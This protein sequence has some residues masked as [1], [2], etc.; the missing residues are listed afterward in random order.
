M[1]RKTY[2]KPKYTNTTINRNVPRQQN[3]NVK[4]T[5]TIQNGNNLGMPFSTI[6]TDDRRFKDV[7]RGSKD[8]L[9]PISTER[10]NRGNEYDNTDDSEEHFEIIDEGCL[11]LKLF[12]GKKQSLSELSDESMSYLWFRR[13]K[14]IFLRMD[15]GKDGQEDDPFV[16][17]DMSLARTDLMKTCDRYI[18]NERSAVT[19]KVSFI[20]CIL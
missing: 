1:S 12:D 8:V 10:L 20:N 16:E 6:V 13:I 15:D 18:E 14:E 7:A 5:S 9:P 3:E 4:Q 11:P 19:K 17:F 2:D